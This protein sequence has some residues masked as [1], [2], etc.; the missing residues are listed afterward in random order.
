MITSNVTTEAIPHETG[1]VLVKAFNFKNL[2]SRIGGSGMEK[3]FQ[4]LKEACNV[5]CSDHLR[6][7]RVH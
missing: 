7:I 6:S 5:I 2:Q 3:E 1:K 4:A